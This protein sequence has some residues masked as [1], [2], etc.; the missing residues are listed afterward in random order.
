MSSQI[1]YCNP[2]IWSAPIVKAGRLKGKR[3]INRSLSDC[4]CLQ[5]HQ[6][7]NMIG[8][9]KLTY[10]QSIEKLLGRRRSIVIAPI[11][12]IR[13]VLDEI[14]HHSLEVVAFIAAVD[15][16]GGGCVHR[17]GAQ[18]V[19]LL[20]PLFEPLG[21]AR[22]HLPARSCDRPPGDDRMLTVP[23]VL[24]GS[25]EHVGMVQGV[26]VRIDAWL[27]AQTRHRANYGAP[28]GNFPIPLKFYSRK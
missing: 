13:I 25:R 23:R 27:S 16:H 1:I 4:Q 9:A 20:P 3:D 12:V 21:R 18:I 7:R 2:L 24:L 17:L 22:H 28:N 26:R 5:P 6:S 11:H 14:V 15:W 19:V 8:N 10:L